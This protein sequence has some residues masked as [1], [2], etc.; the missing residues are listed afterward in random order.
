MK[1]GGL[2]LQPRQ[3]DQQQK[4]GRHMFG[5]IAECALGAQHLHHIAM[6][7]RDRML[8]ALQDSE[9]GQHQHQQRIE[10]RIEGDNR[11]GFMV[12]KHRNAP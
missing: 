10:S 2:G 1:P 5:G 9:I 7:N 4:P 8:A 3:R 6:A 12:K 11:N